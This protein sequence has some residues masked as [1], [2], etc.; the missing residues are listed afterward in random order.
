MNNDAGRLRAHDFVTC[1]TVNLLSRAATSTL[2]LAR[3]P[4]DRYLRERELD[5]DALRRLRE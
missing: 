3:F 4:G 1:T 5:G 2:T